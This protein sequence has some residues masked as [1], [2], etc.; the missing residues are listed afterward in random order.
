MPPPKARRLLLRVEPLRV[1]RV[2]RVEAVRPDRAE[3]ALELPT[4]ASGVLPAVATGAPTGA[5]PQTLQ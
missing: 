1:E 4:A 2:L 3:T 5:S